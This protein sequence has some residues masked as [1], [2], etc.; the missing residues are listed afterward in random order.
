MCLFQNNTE[1]LEI[2]DKTLFLLGNGCSMEY[3][4]P[5][6][7]ELLLKVFQ[8][9]QQYGYYSSF[10]HNLYHKLENFLSILSDLDNKTKWGSIESL[11]IPY[12]SDK[13]NSAFQSNLCSNRTNCLKYYSEKDSVICL[14]CADSKI[15]GLE[16]I[17]F[18]ISYDKHICCKEVNDFLRNLKI[19]ELFYEL[20]RKYKD[21]NK[22]GQGSIEFKKFNV[23]HAYDDL[24][25]IIAEMLFFCYENRKDSKS[26]F[27]FIRNLSSFNG[28]IVSLNYDLLIEQE[29]SQNRSFKLIKPHGSFDLLYYEGSPYLHW[30][31]VPTSYTNIYRFKDEKNMSDFIC[32]GFLPTTFSL[33]IAYADINTHKSIQGTNQ[34]K[35]VREYTI[36]EVERLKNII[37]NC[38][39]VVTIGYSFSEN[40]NKNGLIDNHIIEPLL[41]KKIYVVGKGNTKDIV[42]R[43]KKYY[44]K[45][46]ILHTDFNGFGDYARQIK[47][48]K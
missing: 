16:E 18:K 11:H 35:F 37:P 42:D 40:Y 45:P 36:H 15:T 8:L 24:V 30:N 33:N 13:L 44:K 29:T 34:A 43:V 6:G 32:R 41:S 25:K 27:E 48:H 21:N 26:Y 12:Y 38:D 46:Q 17:T 14:N 4:F 39:K 19:W 20:S 22:Y 9:I 47:Y 10:I 3:G 23:Y 7:N 2:T 28:T 31:V 1:A 5:N